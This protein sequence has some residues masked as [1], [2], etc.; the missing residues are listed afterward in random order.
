MPK[1]FFLQGLPLINGINGTKEPSVIYN[2]P[3]ASLGYC[4]QEGTAKEI[5]SHVQRKCRPLMFQVP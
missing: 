2:K 3:W 5:D 4:S 1:V